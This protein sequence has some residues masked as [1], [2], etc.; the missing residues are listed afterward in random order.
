MKRGLK[1]WMRAL[2]VASGLMLAASIFLPIWKIQL[3]APQYPEGLELKIYANKLGGSVEIVNGLNHYI[4]MRTL[5]AE[6]FPEFTYLP[7]V[8]GFFALACIIVGIV[9]N[10]RVLRGLFIA[11]VL[12][13]V[14][15]MADFW[16][17][18]YDYGH[19]LDPTAPIHVPGM[20][21]QPPLIGF[22]Q[23]L[24]FGAYSIPD[25]GGWLM[26]GTGILL[27]LCTVLTWTNRK[28]K[29]IVAAPLFAMILAISS[30]SSGPMPIQV[31]RDNC[32]FCK[33]GIADARFGAEVVSKK[34]KVWK[35]DDEHC[36]ISF[37][38]E[39]SL[40]KEDINDVYFVR[41]DGGHELLPSGKAVLLQ[42]EALHSPM[43]G[44]IAAFGDKADFEHAKQQM[45]GNEIRWE[46]IK[47]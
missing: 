31:G 30:C 25:V 33:M 17:W 21:Y 36:L 14:L 28:P 16:K 3:D 37:L 46:D 43:G 29:A 22:K 32:D 4:G 26:A 40:K 23:L 12:F 42:S 7:Y 45:S 2:I 5:H 9:G 24:N 20:S 8:L 35:F 1:G 13:A 11:Y 10:F 19:H 44:N 38:K 18:E 47:P 15:A 34:G 27:A 6:D 39:G 41:F